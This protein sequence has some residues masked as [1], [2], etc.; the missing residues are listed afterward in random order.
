MKLTETLRS[1]HQAEAIWKHMSP[2]ARYALIERLPYVSGMDKRTNACIRHIADNLEEFMS[3]EPT[4]E[5][6][7]PDL[8]DGGI[9][10][11]S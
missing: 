4:P 5:D 6:R 1:L 9:H 3:K 7:F 8:D 10:R 11:I 2:L